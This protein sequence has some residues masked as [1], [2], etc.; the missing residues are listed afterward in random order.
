MSKF[1]GFKI[2]RRKY[3]WSYFDFEFYLFGADDSFFYTLFY[4][5]F[6][7]LFTSNPAHTKYVT[8]SSYELIIKTQRVI[9]ASIKIV[10]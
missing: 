10:I 9:R 1:K 2:G 8:K 3:I 4:F 6:N 5:L 7:E